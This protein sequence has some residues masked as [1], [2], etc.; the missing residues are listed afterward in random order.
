[1]AQLVA[2]VPAD[3]LVADGQAASIAVD[4]PVAD[5]RAA[6]IAVD[7]PVADDRVDSTGVVQV[8]DHQVVRHAD[9]TV[10]MGQILVHAA[11]ARAATM[12]SRSADQIA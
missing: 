4:R 8:R 11:H 3:Q 2:G 6:S 10:T 9:A 5:G 7:H 12:T 1:M